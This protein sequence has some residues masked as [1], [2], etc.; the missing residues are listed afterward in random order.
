M[1]QEAFFNWNDS[2]IL[3]FWE[4][5]ARHGFK[6]QADSLL[7]LQQV[8]VKK[9]Q[10]KNLPLL[11]PELAFHRN[12]PICDASVTTASCPRSTPHMQD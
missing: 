6:T 2:M 10:V 7:E 11:Q 3:W 12:V 5:Q 4:T 1:T 8:H 9:D